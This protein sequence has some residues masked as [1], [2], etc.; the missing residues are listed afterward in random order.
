MGGKETETCGRCAMSSVV[1][2]ASADDEGDERDPYAGAR[3]E[4]DERQL[5]A[6]SPAAWLA[7]VKRRID[8][9]ATRLTYGR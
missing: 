7:R 9:Y 4:V 1:G 2:V 8:E 6:V 5:R 3:I